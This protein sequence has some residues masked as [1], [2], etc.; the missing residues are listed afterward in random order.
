LTSVIPCFPD[1]AL[2][3]LEQAATTNQV[4]VEFMSAALSVPVQRT[5]RAGGGV[6]WA[7]VLEHWGGSLSL[8]MRGTA[9]GGRDLSSFTLELNMSNSRTPS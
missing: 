8:V 9:V 3:A 1:D 2:C 4:A 7:P 5:S 6:V